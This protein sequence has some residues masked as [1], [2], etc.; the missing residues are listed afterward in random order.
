MCD[1]D[2]VE[3]GVGGA[4][5]DVDYDH[6]VF[7]GRPR[8]D[9]PGFDVLFEE[10]PDGHAGVETLLLFLGGDG[11]E[12]GGSGEGH[13]HGFDGRGHGVGGVHSSAGAGA[14]AGVADDVEAGGLVNL[15]GEILAIGLECCW[16][17][18]L[19]GGEC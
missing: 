12:G 5:G 7:E 2:E 14:G 8:D 18:V 17:K 3:D 13:S 9:V 4:A 16:L 1:G 10:R 6:G 15:L 11:G 19:A